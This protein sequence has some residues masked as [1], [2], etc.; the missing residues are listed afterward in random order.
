M[1]SDLFCDFIDRKESLAHLISPEVAQLKLT[2]YAVSDQVRETLRAVIA[3]SNV[4]FSDQSKFNLNLLK[5]QNTYT[6]TTGHQLNILGGPLFFTY[7]ILAVIRACQELRTQY[8][9]A[10]FVPVYWAATEDHDYQEINHFYLFG[11]K[12]QW[13]KDVS[14]TPVG[15]ISLEGFEGFAAEW[16]EVPQEVKQC[17]TTSKTLK[18]AHQKLVYHLF[19][20][21]GLLV[22]DA[23]HPDLKQFLVNTALQEIQNQTVSK[24]VSEANLQLEKLGYK[25]QVNPRDCNLFHLMDGKR[26][27]VDVHQDK[28][29]LV[30]SGQ[31]FDRLEYMQLLEDHP[32]V[33]SPN[34]LTRPLYQQLILPNVAYIGGPGELAYWLQLRTMFENFGVSYPA[35]IPRFFGI[36]LPSFMTKKMAKADFAE[37]DLFKKLETIRQEVLASDTQGT[38]LLESIE[39]EFE[40]YKTSVLERLGDQLNQSLQS[41][42]ASAFTRMS[43]ENQNIQKRVKKELEARNS[44]KIDRAA[45][46]LDYVFAGDSFQERRESV[47]TFLINQPHFID[48]VYAAIQPFD[49]RFNVLSNDQS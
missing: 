32:E 45:A 1:F 15:D 13:P 24:S 26:Y 48:E 43:K 14:E 5:E 8:P 38:L 31:S 37:S 27:R 4:D 7:K 20:K 12:H 33:I 6:V 46:I 22:L 40:H 30:G 11:N 49:Y 41:Y 25:T 19:G 44:V 16:G 18:E 29:E 9:E 35:L 17:Y 42:A 23:N 39:T 28:V 36:Y 2:D 21:Y 47:F 10:H 3:E 34:V